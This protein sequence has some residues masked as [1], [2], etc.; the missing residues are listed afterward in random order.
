MTIGGLVMRVGVVVRRPDG[1]LFRGRA[2]VLELV[3]GDGRVSV[4][5]P[6]PG[7]R[8]TS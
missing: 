1:E 6:W 2:R 4:L 5:V 3:R 8:G 7:N